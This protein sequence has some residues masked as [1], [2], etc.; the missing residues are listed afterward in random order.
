[1]PEYYECHITM[2]GNPKL[3]KPLVEE[4]K[5]KFSAIDGDPVLGDGIKCYAT[6]LFPAKLGEDDVK[7]SLVATAA[8]LTCNSGDDDLEVI[9][10]KIE[11]V[12]YDDRSDK[13]KVCT[14]NCP[15][16]HLDDQCASNKEKLAK[17]L[18]LLRDYFDGGIVEDSDD[19][20]Y[21]T[22]LPLEKAQKVYQAIVK[23]TN[24]SNEVLLSI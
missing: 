20:V 4:Q 7:A 2:L 15:G 23:L 16:C 12:V 10:T 22:G 5:W 3:I 1:M 13:V 9:R 17:M 19:V 11:R 21:K 18:D 14:G 6:K 8:A 24:T